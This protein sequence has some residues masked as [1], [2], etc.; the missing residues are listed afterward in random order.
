MDSKRRAPEEPDDAPDVELECLYDDRTNPSELTI[1]SPG[2]RTL[3]TQWIT[4]DRS[5]ARS[6][7]SVR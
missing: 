4:V 1:F 3:A 7:D 5:V 6:L 2:E